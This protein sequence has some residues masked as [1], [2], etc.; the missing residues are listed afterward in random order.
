MAK[1]AQDEELA[2]AFRSHLNETQ[3]QVKRLEAVFESIGTKPRSK[4]CEAM[5]GL[6]A[7]GQE[8]L[9]GDLDESVTD[10]ALVAA[11]RRVEH[12]EMAAYEAL[13]AA[14]QAMKLT[15]GV[16]LLRE[17]LNQETNADKRLASIGKRL[18]TDAARNAAPADKPAPKK[19]ANGKTNAAHSEAHSQTTTDH[20]E[21]QR[22]AEERGGKPA[23]VQGTGGKGDIGMLR[24]E[25]PE[26]PN[27]NDDKLSELSW[28]EFFEKFDERGLALVYQERTADGRTSNF[29]K[30]VSRESESGGK[31]QTAKGK[32]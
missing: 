14:A 16:Q 20:D 4:P 15:E 3:E 29:N 24:L 17:T 8:V 30:L 26:S 32:E 22:W 5:K 9:S 18:V 19:S 6:I 7:E 25:F 2:E 23:C 1:G 13:L 27:A 12:Y 21:I 11:G 31:T 10:I 28:E